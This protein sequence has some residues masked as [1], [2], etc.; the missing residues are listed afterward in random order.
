ME[1]ISDKV[2]NIIKNELLQGNL[3]YL[4]LKEIPPEDL[5]THDLLQIVPVDE[6]IVNV[7]KKV[8]RE[9]NFTEDINRVEKIEII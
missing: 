4:R 1:S 9:K 7:A 6:E 2:L 8:Y 3:I 5:I